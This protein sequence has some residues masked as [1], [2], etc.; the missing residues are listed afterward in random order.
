MVGAPA[1]A[2][3]MAPLQLTLLGGFRARIGTGPALPLPTK[4]AQALLAYLALPAGRAHPRDKL[5]TLLWGDSREGPA[6]T[7]LRQALF[8][9]R[10]AL[11]PGAIRVDGDAVALDPAAVEVD[12]ATLERGIAEGTPA[13]LAAAAQ[14]YQGDLLAGLSVEG[15]A[16]FEEW[17]LGERERLRELALEG[18]AKL[19]A[20]QRNAG[21]ADAAI[22]TGLTLLTL[23]PLQEPVHRTLMRLYLEA[24]RRG[25]ALRQYQQCV[26]VLQREL[27]VEPE[28]ETKQLYQE[29]VRRRAE[30]ASR[31]PQ[32]QRA[33]EGTAP[34]AA[35]P[36]TPLIGRDVELAGLR[37]ALAE[38]GSGH[39]R[40]VA[41]LGEAGVG[42]SRLLAELAQEAR[43]RGS[44]V[45]LG[46]A[47]ESA[48]ILPFGPWVDAFRTGGLIADEGVVGGLE[49]A[50]RVE[51]ARLF[52]ELAAPGLPAASDESRRL[53]EAVARLV[54]HVAAT[55]PIVLM[56]E[57]LHWADEMSL[58]LLSFL[59]RRVPGWPVLVVATAR[60]EELADAPALRRALG[61]LRGEVHFGELV[62]AP[63]SRPDTARLVRVLSRPGSEATAAA[64]LEEQAWTASAGNPF[65]VV[66][67]LRALRDG[68]TLREPG[69]LSLPQRVRDLVVGRLERL[70]EPSRQLLSVAAVIGREF[71]FALLQ[72]ASGLAER[73]A[74]GGVE[75]LVRRRLLH[76]VD[77]G[78]DVTHDRIREVVYGG[79]LP[80]RRKVLHGDV[81]VALE[82]LTAGALDPPAAALAM[83]YRHA[84]AWDKAAVYL[85]RAGRTAAA[86]S[87]LQDARAC[88]EQALDA[89][90]KLPESQSTLE[91]A[92][93]IRLELRPVVSLLGDLR[94]AL[95]RMREAEALAEKLNDERR[96]GRVCT[97]TTQQLLMLG[98]LDEALASGT[99]AQ[100]L[101][102]SLEDLELR[103]VS[104]SFLGQVHHYRG[105]YG[106]QVEVITENLAAL[107][108]DWLYKDLGTPVPLSIFDRIQMVYALA[109]LGR[110]AE[111]AAYEVEMIRFAEGT[112]HPYAVGLAHLTTGMLHVCQGN[113]SRAHPPIE[114]SLT[115]L[116][117][118]NIVLMLPVAVTTS[119][120]TLAMLGRASEALDRL[121]EGEQLLARQELTG[122]QRGRAY[123]AMGRTSLLLGR[124]D[125]AQ[126][127]ASGAIECFARQSGYAARAVHLLGDIATQPD[128]FD[129]ERG[130]AHYRD[131]LALAESCGMRPLVALCHLGLG[132]M[133]ARLGERRQAREHLGTAATMF[134]E[135]DMAFWLEQTEAALRQATSG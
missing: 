59:G 74:A 14:C 46:R 105:E 58:R 45:L 33:G 9:L 2:A 43:R 132:R 96:R 39:G 128:R 113:W 53:F 67:T 60:E 101:A 118:G 40:A 54:G 73:E 57:D 13:A 4:K 81:A 116:R 97:F 69:T 42:K 122:L 112:H 72:R 121:R 61:E 66:E 50:W 20:H 51:L 99:R 125:D 110:F 88:F 100:A 127:L 95:E 93:E 94:R 1:W 21:D 16:G 70:S 56:L 29:T 91:Q 111:A 19:L 82:A 37:K 80:P 78:F 79:L 3:T 18:L 83:H 7:S 36:E 24:G 52:P 23:D 25:A 107:P 102:R 44:L 104:T 98:E 71:D 15:A 11:P 65:V 30:A 130:E 55:Q 10:R 84:E 31:R 115:M 8:G 133:H 117:A 119:A 86:R 108:A 134:R 17:L 64:R 63:L 41:V 131:A 135:M 34:E 126:R 87:A 114:H 68:L 27:G 103:L 38:A 76:G 5:A 124:L 48:Q 85:R 77:E 22:Q 62:L 12:V 120:W 47:Y 32:P 49:P 92:F 106:R 89:L 35:V 90:D 129:A 123:H 6:R 28:T 26:A 109:E 75:E